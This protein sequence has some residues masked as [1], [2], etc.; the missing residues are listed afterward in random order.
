MSAKPET[1]QFEAEV[2]ELLG[3]MIHSLYTETDIFLRELISNASD[4]LDKRR[5]AGLTDKA[6]YDEQEELGI[7]L[8]VDAEARTLSIQDNGI[9]M[10]RDELASNLGTIARSG[11]REFLEALKAKKQGSAEQ[12]IGQFGVGFYSSFMVADEV[13]VVS[14]KAGTEEAHQWTSKADG[15]YALSPAT[16]ERVGTTVTLHL[17]PVDAEAGGSD[18]TDPFA[19]R[20]IIKKHSDFVE[21]PIHMDVEEWELE[22]DEDGNPKEG[23][24]RTK[25]VRRQVLN[26]RTPL[27]TR[28]KKDVT[29]EEYA[30]F[31]RHVT[32]GFDEPRVTVHLRAEVPV[33]F[34]ALLF[35]PSEQP[36]AFMQT[37]DA[38]SKLALYVRRVL[39][40]PECEDLLP[41]WLR[42]VRGAVECSDLPLNVSRQTLQENP[43]TGKIRKHLVAKLLARL[44]DLL[45][46]D[47]ES[48]A[49][50]FQAFG[51]TLKEGIYYGDDDDQRISRLCLFETTGEGGATT[52]AEYV[53]RMPAGQEAIYTITGGDLE[54]LRQ[55]PHL[56]AYRANGTEVLLLH[57]PV[58]EWML[59]RLTS[60]DEK[61]LR[62]VTQGDAPAE[63]EAA[64][65]A[66]AAKEEAHK[67]LL[68]TLAGHLAEHVKEVRFSSRLAD[69]PA[70][71]VSDEGALSPAMERMMREMHGGA[72]AAKRVLELNPDHPLTERLQALHADDADAALLADYAQLLYG[73]ALLAEGS[74]LPDPI[75]FSRKLTDLL[76]AGGVSTS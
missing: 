43:V 26:S 68:E 2:Q 53:D 56:E 1:R 59:S 10:T 46:K 58:D 12:L 75:G 65:E 55:S 39:I 31:Y 16:R 66:R 30:Q 14:R 7:E 17:K 35:V 25:V 50:F 11:T 74:P 40:M 73:Q 64:K 45:A 42:F 49:A 70:V 15:T 22:K 37:Q 27:W 52:L 13:A 41:P 32:H 44:G 21:Y 47:R 19:I 36:P 5:I 38:K 61:P 48:Y 33:E 57:D 51:G 34:Q 8:E 67:G 3:L 28:N 4:A 62:A 29:D 9:G 6:V 71:L 60:F 23:G 69:S 54:T 18:L 24:E 20:R 72:P 63:D 76:V